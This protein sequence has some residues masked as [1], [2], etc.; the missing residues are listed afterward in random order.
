M[1]REEQGIDREEERNGQSDRKKE[2]TGTAGAVKSKNG[3]H[4]W[5]YGK[6]SED[7]AKKKRVVN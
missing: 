7:Q 6:K 3:K 4:E 2:I 1:Q 5:K